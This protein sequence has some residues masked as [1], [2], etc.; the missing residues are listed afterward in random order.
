MKLSDFKAFALGELGWS[1]ERWRMATLAEF[2]MAADGYWRN[3][4]RDVA[5]L[6][7]EITFTLITGNPYIKD[8]SKPSTPKEIYKIS[9]D[10]KKRDIK[11]P[12][13]VSAE[14]LEAARKLLIGIRDGSVE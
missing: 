12:P 9:D 7:R 14:E 4:E 11:K 3:W 13:P 5:W 8:G 2:C 10:D 1:I 6:M